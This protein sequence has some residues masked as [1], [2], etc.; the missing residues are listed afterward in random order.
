MWAETNDW[1]LTNRIQ[2]KWWD[3]TPRLGYQKTAFCLVHF[4]CC[5]LPQSLWR[6]L[7][8][9]LWAAPW[10]PHDKELTKTSGWQW[11]TNTLQASRPQ[12]TQS[13]Q[14]PCKWILLQLSFQLS[15]QSWPTAW[16]QRHERPYTRG[17]Q[18]SCTLI[19]EAQ[20]L[21]NILLLLF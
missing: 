17:I 2:H 13:C 11:E 8:A 5:S 21:W 1:L 10:G 7:A 12:G 3:V 6:R 14:Q 16:L 19:P 20:D 4:L 15:S 9:M 18:L